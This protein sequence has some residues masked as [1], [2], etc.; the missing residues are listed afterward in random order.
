MYLPM[1]HLCWYF[2]NPLCKSRFLSG[3]IFFLPE[4]LPLTFLIMLVCQ[5]QIHLALCMSQQI[6]ILTSFLK[7]IFARYRLIILPPLLLSRCSFTVFSLA[8]F[9]VRNLMS[10]LS[11]FFCNLLSAFRIFS[12]YYSGFSRETEPIRCVCICRKIFILTNYSLQVIDAGSLKHTGWA[13][14][15][16]FKSEGQLMQNSFLLGGKSVFYST[17]VFN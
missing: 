15:L 14:R 2:F 5:Q 8:L 9:P 13:S 11:F 12:L 3:I 7:H 6:F 4:W 17:Q 1:G 10:Y 16:Y